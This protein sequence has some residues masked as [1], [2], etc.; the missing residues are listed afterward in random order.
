MLADALF[1]DHVQR[2]ELVVVDVILE[3]DELR[4]PARHLAH[5]EAH[6]VFLAGGDHAVEGFERERDRLFAQNVAAAARR[7]DDVFLV[8]IGGNANAHHIEFFRGQSRV[9]RLI[10]AATIGLRRF[11]AFFRAAADHRRDGDVRHRPVR[12][13]MVLG[14]ISHTDYR[15][16]KHIVSLSAPPER[17]P[18]GAHYFRAAA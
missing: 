14:D 6:A 9:E 7:L 17:T 13:E 10:M 2:A 3:S 12:F 18:G 1:I 5:H 15:N 4:P 11:L 16:F 8:Q